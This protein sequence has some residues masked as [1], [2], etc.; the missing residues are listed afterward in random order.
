MITCKGDEI[1][2][3]F[4]VYSAIVTESAGKCNRFFKKFPNKPHFSV[5][6]RKLSQFSQVFGGKTLLFSHILPNPLK[7]SLFSATSLYPFCGS[8]KR[9]EKSCK[10]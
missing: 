4:S 3:P 7:S 5:K 10:K 2:S 6:N 1:T 8:V 9:E